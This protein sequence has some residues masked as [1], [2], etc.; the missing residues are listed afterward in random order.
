MK[1]RVYGIKEQN[2][3]IIKGIEE[4]DSSLETMQ[5]YVGGYIEMIPLIPERKI[6]IFSDEDASIFDKPV[7]SSWELSIGNEKTIIGIKGNHFV[8]KIQP[9]CEEEI[10]SLTDEDIQEIKRIEREIKKS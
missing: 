10:I 6:V 5:D 8:C 7:T 3:K 4:I 2:G 9:N 1:I